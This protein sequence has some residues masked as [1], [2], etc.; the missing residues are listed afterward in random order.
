MFTIRFQDD[1]V[2]GTACAV[3]ENQPNDN[4]LL[5][6]YGDTSR[7][8]QHGRQWRFNG[9]NVKYGGGCYQVSGWSYALDHALHSLIQNIWLKT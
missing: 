5:E 2:Q 1:S 9:N 7:C 3:G 8:V 4:D 6:S